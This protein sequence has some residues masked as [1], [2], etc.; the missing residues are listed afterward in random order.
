MCTCM[1]INCI[2][3]LFF[4]VTI[5]AIAGFQ[6]VLCVKFGSMH[7]K[8]K[9]PNLN[10]RNQKTCQ[11]ATSLKDIFQHFHKSV[12][13]ARGDGVHRSIIT[14]RKSRL[15][16]VSFS[17]CVLFAYAQWDKI[18]HLNNKSCPNKRKM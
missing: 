4:L 10:Q 18:N 9:S 12:L 17:K 2:F 5:L 3:F 8:E 1:L 6:D 7:I 16:S 15:Y 13:F 11:H 14:N